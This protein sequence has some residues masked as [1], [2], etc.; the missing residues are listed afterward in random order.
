LGGEIHA[1][2]L[3]EKSAWERGEENQYCEGENELRQIER[4]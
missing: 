4:M 1:L 2:V 3:R